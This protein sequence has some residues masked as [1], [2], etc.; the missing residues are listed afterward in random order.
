MKKRLLSTFLSLCMMLTMVP[1]MAFAAESTDGDGI[2]TPTAFNSDA[3]G[4]VLYVDPEVSG[5]TDTTFQDLQAA[6]NAASSGDT[7]QLL[8]DIDDVEVTINKDNLTLDLNTYTIRDDTAAETINTNPIILVAKNSSGEVLNSL[9]I[10]NGSICG[11][12]NVEGGCGIYSSSVLKNLTVENVEFRN[13]HSGVYSIAGSGSAV[14]FRMPLIAEKGAAEVEPSPDTSATFKNCV[15]EGNRTNFSNNNAAHGGAIYLYSIQ[16]ICI[17]DCTFNGNQAGSTDEL[18]TAG[19]A[20]SIQMADTV[21]FKGS[22][23]TNNSAGSNGGAVNVQSCDT[24]SFENCSFEGNHLTYSGSNVGGALDLS[25]TGEK[26]SP[27]EII[28]CTFKN[29]TAPYGNGGA[30]SIIGNNTDNGSNK[31]YIAWDED[32]VVEINNSTFEGNS[33]VNGGAICVQGY[34]YVTITG[35]LTGQNASGSG[36]ALFATGISTSQGYSKDFFPEVTVNGNISGNSAGSGGGG[37]TASNATVNV[38]GDVT[39]NQASYGSGFYATGNET[40]VQITGNISGNKSTSTTGGGGFYAYYGA[41]VTVNGC[42]SDNTSPKGGGGFTAS[43][44]E[45]SVTGDIINNQGSYGGG[46]YAA[47]SEADVQ[48]TGNIS[49]NKSTSATGGGGF[50]AFNGANVTVNGMITDNTTVGRGGGVC[51]DTAS[52][53]VDLTNADVY[54][55]HADTQGADIF[56]TGGTLEISEPGSDW[57][58]DVCNHFIDGWYTDSSEARWA[59]GSDD[60]TAQKAGTFTDEIALIAAH[61]ADSN[62]VTITPADITIYTGGAGYGSVVDANGE[63]LATTSSTNGLPE[64]G[65]HLTLS[66]DVQEWLANNGVRDGEDLSGN[67]KFTYE[68]TDTNGDPVNREWVLEYAGIYDTERNVYTLK[69]TN[70]SNPAV[71]LMYFDDAD[72]DGK[73]GTGETVIADDQIDMSES[74]VS[75]EYAMTIN[76]GALDQSTVQAVFTVNGSTFPCNVKVGTGELT[77]KSVTD[78]DTTSEI[79][80]SAPSGDATTITAVDNGNITYYVNDSKVEVDAERV[81]LLV[82]EVSNNT[83]YNEAMAS[84]AIS[85]V[86]LTNADCEAKYLDLVD[87]QNGNAVVTASDGVTIYWPVPEGAQNASNF[88]IV[89]YTNMDRSAIT[90]EDALNDQETEIIEGSKTADG[91]YITFT[92]DSFSPFVLV[93]EEQG[94]TTPGTGGGG[95]TTYYTLKYESNGGTAYDDERY[96]SNTVVDL[97]KVPSREGYTFTGWYADAELTEQISEIKMTSNKT[98]YAGWEVTGVPDWLNGDDHF[99]YVIGYSDGTVKPLNNISRAEVA[100]IFFRLLKPEIRDEYLTQTSQ[101]TDVSADAWYNTAVSTMAA[102]GIVNGRTADTFAPDASITRA[103]FAA[104]CARFDTNKR[105]GDSNFSDIAG[106]WAEAEIERAATLGWINGYSDGTFHPDNAI[107]RAEAMTMINRVL[108]RLPETEDDLLD[109]MNV[110]PDN[111]PSAWYYLAV[112]EATNSHDFDRKDDGVHE[113][114]TGMTADPDW[115][116]YQ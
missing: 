60:V 7:I 91:K 101:F 39:D 48:V 73:L 69:P 44:A 2:T 25:M 115:M 68:G 23:F 26:D 61:S 76:P 89:H 93:W 27:A 55:N 50:Y 8:G 64:P 22:E 6:I 114:W 96:T 42:L 24:A 52:G 79:L 19:G 72:G 17:E 38:T 58:L 82:D 109:D 9:T 15:F 59:C 92:A 1:T 66:S 57:I 12:E 103:E 75:K 21:T 16:T 98:V 94:S 77:V 97:D 116:Q 45:V 83:D 71:R 31:P 99:A 70:D 67:L 10:K 13:I 86:Y 56:H 54:N 95:G 33:A 88:Y 34:S 51:S 49:G 46:F 85:K 18:M 111:Q 40:D 105:D 3:T 80:T 78:Q 41:S 84:H 62:T 104:I 90:S 37:F 87:T 74:S 28:G 30:I 14:Y 4:K 63:P 65:Y 112:Q 36:G 106:H 108:Q 113:T 107:T 100:T 102:L 5:D 35:D 43:N 32:S 20:V 53:T 11:S 81:K 29:N 47:G 110:W